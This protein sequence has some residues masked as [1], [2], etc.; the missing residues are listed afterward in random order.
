M[1]TKKRVSLIMAAILS[2]TVLSTACGKDVNSSSGGDSASETTVADG[3]TG[4]S[5]LVADESKDPASDPEAESTVQPAQVHDTSK[6]KYGYSTLSA[7]EKKIYD[8]MVKAVSEFKSTVEL[9]KSIPHATYAKIFGMVYFQEAQLFWLLGRMQTMEQDMDKIP[10][11]YR[12]NSTEVASMQK[13]IDAKVKEIEAS[14]PANATDMD[15][16][17]VFHDYIVLNNQFTK[18][19][20]YVQTVYGALVD[21]KIQCE[22]YAKAMAYLCDRSGIENLLI[23]GTNSEQNSHAWNKI[24]LDGEWYVV[25]TTWDDPMG[26]EDNPEFIRYNYFGAADAEIIGKTHFPDTPSKATPYAFDTP[27]ATATKYNYF[28]YVG[29]TANT[30]DEAIALIKKELEAANKDKLRQVQIKVGS[31]A[32][33]EE[34]KS[35]LEANKASELFKILG[36]INNSAPNKFNVSSVAPKADENC[37]T[38]QIGVKYA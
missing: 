26:H 15:K 16:V 38:Y 5:D 14:L 24:K 17:M 8:D 33:L 31:S 10:L 32:V 11:S 13:E 36:D 18:E 12:F 1:N 25:D 21:G 35:K 2:L 9:E 7:E 37:L 3:T 23:T 20:D 4:S 28:N 19:G 30:Y 34:L 29:K 6:L 27:A 22:G